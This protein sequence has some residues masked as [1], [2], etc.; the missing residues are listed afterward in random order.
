MGKTTYAE[1][2]ALA[3]SKPEK[4][5]ESGQGM[6]QVPKASAFLASPKKKANQR[7]PDATAYLCVFKVCSEAMLYKDDQGI[8]LFPGIATVNHSVFLVTLSHPNAYPQIDYKIVDSFDAMLQ[9]KIAEG[10]P[11]N[12]EDLMT[13]LH[14]VLINTGTFVPYNLPYKKWQRAFYVAGDAATCKT[15]VMELDNCIVY[16][17]EHKDKPKH[18][19]FPLK[20]QIGK[21]VGFEVKKDDF[22]YPFVEVAEDLCAAEMAVTPLQVYPPQGVRPLVVHFEIVDDTH[23]AMTFF[24]DTYRHRYALSG[25]GL[26]MTKE[27]AS[28]HMVAQ[29]SNIAQKRLETYYLMG[30][31]DV[32]VETEATFVTKL[33]TEDVENVIIDLRVISSVTKGT[34]TSS[35]VEALSEIPS[36]MVQYS[37]F[38]VTLDLSLRPM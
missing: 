35:F 15:F 1:V 28:T 13:R 17:V 11:Q 19:Q 10:R 9:G 2:S 30:S 36:L 20:V 21:N 6:P 37:K 33:L 25:A 12:W 3:V 27:E 5:Q 16:T 7:S 22:D 32:S 23:I 14:I 26:E 24:G 18:G 31:R 34:T 4:Q 29:S 38:Y 8:C